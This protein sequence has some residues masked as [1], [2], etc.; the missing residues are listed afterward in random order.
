MK[1]Y[2]KRGIK[3]WMRNK[4]DYLG[5]FFFGSHS[6][7]LR[8]KRNVSPLRICFRLIRSLVWNGMCSWNEWRQSGGPPNTGGVNNSRKCFEAFLW[9]PRGIPYWNMHKWSGSSLSSDNRSRKQCQQ[10]SWER[11]RRAH[12]WYWTRTIWRTAANT[13]W[14]RP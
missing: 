7:I 11:C 14:M 10:Q 8:F 13:V 3:L 1:N 6:L 5:M 4:L 9:T 2:D 12:I